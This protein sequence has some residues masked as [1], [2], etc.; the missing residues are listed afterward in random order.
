MTSLPKFIFKTNK[1]L[2]AN[3]I[4]MVWASKKDVGFFIVRMKLQIKS[5]VVRRWNDV[6]E[7]H[8]NYSV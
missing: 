7:A 8:E 3:S 2:N 1:T 4:E 5:R 6:D